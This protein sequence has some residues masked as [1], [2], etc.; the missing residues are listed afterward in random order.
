MVLIE[1]DSTTDGRWQG[2]AWSRFT[3]I[4]FGTLAV[5]L[6]G[7]CALIAAANPYGNLPVSLAGQHAIMDTNQ[8]YQYPAIARSGLYDSIVIGTS[9]SRL[10]RPE[11]LNAAFSGQFA[12]LAMDDSTAWEQ[13]RLASLF[14]AS[15]P[16]PRTLVV[17]LDHV[18]CRENAGSR[19]TTERGFPEWMFDNDPWNDLQWMLNLRSVEISLRRIA[20][21]LGLKEARIPFN[22]YEVFVPPEEQ[23]D[24]AKAKAKLK[25][26]KSVAADSP[27]PTLEERA[28]LTFPA[29]E[30]LGELLEQKWKRVILVVTPIHMGAQ[31]VAGQPAAWRENEC[32][33]RIAAMAESK[34]VPLVDFRIRSEITSRD[35]NYWDP[36]HYRTGIAERIVAGL[37]RALHTKVDDPGGDWRML[38]G[39][40]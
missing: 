33:A 21:A 24:L 8:R 31:P 23:Y 17:G 37:S 25:H 30:W 6:V 22:G 38:S 29:L 32:K 10:L 12:N 39:G 1:P 28:A 18:W 34:G 14:V 15:V 4:L 13:Y 5:E 3:R 11:A 35:E 26:P 7:A 27:A 2:A 36:L 9:T 16:Q 20:Y 40:R 19:R